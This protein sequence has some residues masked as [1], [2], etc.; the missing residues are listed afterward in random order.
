MLRS[1]LEVQGRNAGTVVAPRSGQKCLPP[2]WQAEYVWLTWLRK[3][4]MV[5]WAAGSVYIL[6]MINPVFKDQ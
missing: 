6:Y 1:R 5:Q 4:F 2:H 3:L